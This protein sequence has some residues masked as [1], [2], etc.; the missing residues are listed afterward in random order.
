MRKVRKTALPIIS[1]SA[2]LANHRSSKNFC[3]SVRFFG[4]RSGIGSRNFRNN[5]H[6]RLVSNLKS[7]GVRLIGMTILE[8]CHTKYRTYRGSS[9]AA[10]CHG[11]QPVKQTNKTIPNCHRSCDGTVLKTKNKN[12][13]RCFQL[14]RMIT[15]EKRE[16][17]K[18]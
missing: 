14:K 8:F 15:F 11:K 10:F 13:N 18:K 6:A 7:F 5:L 4:R 17:E 12:K 1:F 3:K 2:V 9:E 16:S